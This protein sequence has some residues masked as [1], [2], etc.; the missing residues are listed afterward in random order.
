MKTLL[1]AA[2]VFSLPAPG[3]SAA[4]AP[5]WVEFTSATTPPTP[6]PAQAR[7][8]AREPLSCQG[9]VLLSWPVARK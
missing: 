6:F 1:L 2:V 4:L 8:G 9:V 3:I 7:S 5:E